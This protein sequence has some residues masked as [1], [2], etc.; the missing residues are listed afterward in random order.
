MSELV[1]N[2]LARLTSMI[3]AKWEHGLPFM[4][5]EIKSLDE[6]KVQKHIQKQGRQYWF[7][8]HLSLLTRVYPMGTRFDSSNY[9]PMVGW[10]IGAQFVALN[11]QTPDEYLLLN[12]ALFELNG[13]R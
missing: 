4:P 11:I 2:D 12:Q 3:G 7:E 6:N 5:W 10:S 9:N 13:G 1:S 8:H